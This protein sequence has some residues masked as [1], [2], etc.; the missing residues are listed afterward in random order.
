MDWKVIVV[1]EEVSACIRN[2][3]SKVFLCI[4]LDN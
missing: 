1:D 2:F 3:G 4:L